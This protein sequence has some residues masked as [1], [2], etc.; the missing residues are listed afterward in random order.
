MDEGRRVSSSWLSLAVVGLGWMLLEMHD[1]DQGFCWIGLDGIGGDGMG[2]R[3]DKEWNRWSG[4]GCYD[5]VFTHTH[6]NKNETKKVG[7][8]Q[9]G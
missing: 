7:K 1:C 4:F 5:S 6:K 3:R 2:S 9:D 8:L